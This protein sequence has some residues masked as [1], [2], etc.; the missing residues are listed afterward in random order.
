MSKR[1]TKRRI[2]HA[3]SPDGPQAA[4]LSLS[5]Y[6]QHLRMLRDRER[7]LNVHRSV[8]VQLLL[9]I[10]QRDGLLRQ[11]LVHRLHN[12]QTATIA[13]PESHYVHD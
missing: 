12:H 5:I 7:E 9:E 1:K 11:E 8:L 2:Y 4:P 6:P 3:P 10:D 13:P